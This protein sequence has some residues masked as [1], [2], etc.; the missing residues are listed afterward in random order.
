MGYRIPNLKNTIFQKFYPAK[1]DVRPLTGGKALPLILNA[2]NLTLRDL[3][4][5]KLWKYFKN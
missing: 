3:N 5:I 2:Y 4:S 1:I